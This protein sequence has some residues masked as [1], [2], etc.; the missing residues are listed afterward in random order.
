MS[1]I[2]R[3]AL[4]E[5]GTLVKQTIDIHNLTAGYILPWP[6]TTAP[7]HTLICDGS[8]ISRVTYAALFAVIGTTYGAGD[9]STTFALPDFR[10]YFLRGAN[11]TNSAA[12]GTAQGDAIR[13]MTGQI[14]VNVTG[15]RGSTDSLV[16][17]TVNGGGADAGAFGVST[18][19][20]LNDSEDWSPLTAATVTGR[21]G[22]GQH[23][24]FDAAR[25]VPT[26]AEVRPINYAVNWVIVYE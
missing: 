16:H 8:A 15:G 4:N 18:P 7:E 21:S 24:I 2:I 20:D 1:K 14:N 22:W 13:K 26:A 3:A 19:Q 10:G 17:S 6:G 9:G 25:V 12:M 11:G 23:V 5:N